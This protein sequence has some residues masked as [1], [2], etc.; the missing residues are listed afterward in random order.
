MQQL[1]RRVEKG[2]QCCGL[3]G[4]LGRRGGLKV[5]SRCRWT[6]RVTVIAD[7]EVDGGGRSFVVSHTLDWENIVGNPCKPSTEKA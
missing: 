4:G 1:L 7:V 6:R 3:T 2:L 5:M